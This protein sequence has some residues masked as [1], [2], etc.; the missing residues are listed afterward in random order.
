RSIGGAEPMPPHRWHT[1]D[2]AGQ[3]FQVLNLDHPELAARVM[4]DMDAGIEVY[5]DQRWKCTTRLCHVLLENPAWVAGRAVLVLGAG[6]GLE[7]V[8]IG[9]LCRTLYINHLTPASLA[10]CA[11]QLRQNGVT[12]FVCLPGRYESLS[13]PAVDLIVASF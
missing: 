10:L 4:H 5:Y 9:R 1:I 11:E 6:V 12:G 2:I 8:V 7:T 3:D 13:L